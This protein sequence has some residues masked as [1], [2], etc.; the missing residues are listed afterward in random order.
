MSKYNWLYR[1]N[2]L[3][4]R[5]QVKVTTKHKPTENIQKIK[6]TALWKNPKHKGR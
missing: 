6:K 4:K 3:R 5:R 1:T 2:F